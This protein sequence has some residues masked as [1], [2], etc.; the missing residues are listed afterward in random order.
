MSRL[1]GKATAVRVRR[2]VVDARYQEASI[3]ATHTP[4]FSAEPGVRLIPVN[5]L[6]RPPGPASGY[7]VIGGGKTAMDAC[8]WL[9]EVGV[10]PESI[11]WIRPRDAWLLNRAYQQPLKLVTWLIEGVSLCLE[12]AAQAEDVN[13]LF[14]RLEACGQLIRLDPAVRPTMYRCAT[15]SQDEL[16]SLRRIKNVVRLGRVVHIAPDQIVLEQGSIPTGG[17]QVHVDCSAA[18]LRLAPAR[19]VFADGRITLQQ[20]RACQPA[21]ERPGPRVMSTESALGRACGVERGALS[22][23]LQ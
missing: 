14:A 2:R 20:I 21:L 4:S 13:D 3:P 11:R 8:T 10:P 17:G 15:V 16:V 19:P 18:G 22:S 6:V 5:D 1:T 12:A 9:L 7:T 23:G